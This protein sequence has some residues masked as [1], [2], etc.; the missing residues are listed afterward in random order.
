MHPIRAAQVTCL[1][2]LIAIMAACAIHKVDP[3]APTPSQQ[4]A[5]LN[6]MQKIADAS[7][8]IES[9]AR[10]LQDAEIAAFDTHS[11]KALDVAKHREIQQG[12]KDFF[13]SSKEAIK[14]ASD[15]STPDSTRRDAVNAEVTAANKLLK[16][17]SDLHSAPLS[18]FL[19][20]LETAVLSVNLVL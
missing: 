11:L 8:T 19:V 18:A 4:V 15:V 16:H 5:K 14:T 12:F 1:V 6:E 13:V 2:V 9:L 17:F 7:V 3:N 10:D 20:A